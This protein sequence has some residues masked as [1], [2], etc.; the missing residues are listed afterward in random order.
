MRLLLGVLFSYLA[1]AN[2]IGLLLLWADKRRASHNLWRI[3]EMTL[4]MP[5]I[6]GGT[7]GCLIGMYL[8]R[9]KTRHPKFTIGMPL[10]LLLQA[11]LVLWFLFFS[12][13]A[14]FFM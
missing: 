7:P 3:S 14:V 8:F 2:L 12:P 1:V 11:G 9:H 6:L 10:L 4:F 13:Y 5:A